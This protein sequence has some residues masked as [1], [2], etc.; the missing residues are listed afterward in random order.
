M[1]RLQ[2]IG[3]SSMFRTGGCPVTLGSSFSL[4]FSLR[5]SSSSRVSQTAWRAGNNGG[6]GGRVGVA[7][8]AVK[9][10]PSDFDFRR[11]TRQETAGIIEE[12]YPE[13]SDLAEEGEIVVVKK[14]ADYV[15]RRTDGYVE[16]DLIIV[17][18]TSHV[19]RD[20][21][22]NVERVLR[23]VRPQNVVVE[24]CRSRVGIMYSSKSTH[25]IKLQPEKKQKTN[26][27][28]MGGESFLG[29]MGRSLT[30]GGQSGLAL[31][32][33]LAGFSQKMS[34]QV[35]TSIGAEFCAARKISEEIGAQIVLGDRPIEI[36]LERAWK[37]LKW[38]EQV[39]LV[40]TLLQGI[41]STSLCI[42]EGNFKMKTDDALSTMFR[43]LSM[44][45]PSL[46]QPLIHERDVYLAWS[47][48]RSKAV[49]GSKIVV[50]IIG[51]GH[52]C[53][54][55]HSLKYNQ[56]HL[57]FRDLV[58]GRR[59]SDTNTNDWL[60]GILWS[61]IRDTI[62]TIIFFWFFEHQYFTF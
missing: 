54:V 16:P 61:F 29:A 5:K 6:G 7:K 55:I 46:L 1:E 9:A 53:G 49:N 24:L 41:Y 60:K 58:G 57:R 42:S 52:M 25:S 47:L 12:M 59:P 35:G 22:A 2:F 10:P 33:L 8:V 62:I 18:G 4:S 28:S 44:F 32:L 40:S 17:L 30:L 3:S 31:R 48:K 19:S 56:D 23:A 43:E 39:K 11:E 21:A 50:G 51:R 15:E 14:R 27:F 37:S 13:L 38:T 34:S 20:S 45:Y 26:L 36:T